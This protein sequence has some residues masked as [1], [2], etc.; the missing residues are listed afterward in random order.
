[1]SDNCRKMEAA[2]ETLNKDKQASDRKC[3]QVSKCFLLTL[4]TTTAFVPED[5]AI[6]MTL[7]LYRI[8]NEQI[9][10]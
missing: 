7:L 10:I 4:V 2:I 3:S 1:M 9:D 5:F 6:K 8:L